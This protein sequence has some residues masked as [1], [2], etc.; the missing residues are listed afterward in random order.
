VAPFTIV[1]AV[2]IV[3]EDIYVRGE[4]PRP[5]YQLIADVVAGDSGAGLITDDGTLGGV[6]W[7]TSET[8]KERGFAISA[9]V[10]TDVLAAVRTTS[11]PAAAV[12]CA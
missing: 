11:E 3:S 8:T 1:K 4:H 10:I 9:S 2:S 6:I 12:A 5:G 7:A